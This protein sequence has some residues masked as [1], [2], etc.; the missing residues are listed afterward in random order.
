VRQKRFERSNK[1]A[2]GKLSYLGLKSFVRHVCDLQGS[3]A[4]TIENLLST[5]LSDGTHR[6]TG[7]YPSHWMDYWHEEDGGSDRRGVRPQVGTTLLKKEMDGLAFKSGY[8]VA[9][10]DVSN[11][12]LLPEL[13]K[14]GARSRNG[15][16]R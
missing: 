1:V 13:V 11:A 5:S 4:A 14:K 8:E 16:F 3:S 9:W 2:T 6:P 12:E 10:D 7:D 15:I